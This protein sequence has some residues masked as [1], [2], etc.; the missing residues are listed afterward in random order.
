[1]AGSY[2]YRGPVLVALNVRVTGFLRGNSLTLF[3]GG[4]APPVFD[5]RV[6]GKSLTGVFRG[7][8]PPGRLEAVRVD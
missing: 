2:D 8:G 5:G 7:S 3:E 1:M 4:T 6:E